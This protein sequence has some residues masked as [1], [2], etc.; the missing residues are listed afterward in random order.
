MVNDVYARC[1]P[2]DAGEVATYIPELSKAN[3][4]DFGV[5]VATAD[6]RLFE[7][8]T[9]D[10]PFTIQSI[11]RPFTFGMA[12]EELGHDKVFQHVGV[13]PSGDAFTPSTATG[14]W[15]MCWIGS[16]LLPAG[17]CQ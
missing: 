5:C 10:R 4:D 15:S 16:V 8:G 9:C 13:E 12:L 17:G 7:A 1:L 14:P 11:S 2:I 6:G 3:P